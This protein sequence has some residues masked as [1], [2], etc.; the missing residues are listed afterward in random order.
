[1]SI[2]EK[3]PF[4]NPSIKGKTRQGGINHQK[5]IDMASNN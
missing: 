3:V 2:L 1:L 4:L 5:I